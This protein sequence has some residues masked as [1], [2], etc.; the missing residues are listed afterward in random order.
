MSFFSALLSSPPSTPLSKYTAGNGLFYMAMGL[1]IFAWPGMLP[2]VFG[3]D[4]F[5]AREEGLMRVVGFTVVVIG[6]FYFMGARTRADSFGLATVVDRLL[7]PFFLLPL[8]FT[9]VV[10]PHLVLP[11]AILDPILGIGAFII[12]S[13]TRS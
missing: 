8:A 6:W 13:R 3:A 4:A 11:F 9:G 1:S 12:W 7:V 2:L 10:D 5:Q